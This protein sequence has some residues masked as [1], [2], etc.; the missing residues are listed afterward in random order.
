MSKIP[1]FG[2]KSKL[3]APAVLKGKT[4]LNLLASDC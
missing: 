1:S 3:K 4:R 2:F